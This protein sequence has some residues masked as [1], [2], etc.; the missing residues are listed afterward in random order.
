MAT[1][2]DYKIS[3]LPIQITDLKVDRSKLKIQ[4]LCVV[5]YG[6][7]PGRTFKEE[8]TYGNYMAFTYISRGRGTFRINGGPVQPLEAGSLFWE[9]PGGKYEFGPY[10]DA[11]WDEYYIMFEGSRTKEWFDS[12]ILSITDSVMHVGL[13][14]L[15][16]SK[17]EAIG[18]YMES[19]VPNNIDRAALLLESLVYEFSQTH[20]TYKTAHLYKQKQEIV[21]QVLEAIAG[22]LYGPWNEQEIWERN[23]IS[24]STLRRIVLQNTGFPLNEYVNRL[25]VSEAKKLL[26]HTTLQIKEIAHSLGY[27]DVAY[28]SRLFKKYAQTSALSFRKNN[29]AGIPLP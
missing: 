13:D 27:S 14:P 7:L 4:S 28:F 1:F 24:R 26:N 18:A 21:L 25:K 19:G 2:L 15:W 10:A 8:G 20:S 29:K 12:G 23:H 6:H 11:D 17:L 22:S 3:P 5:Q 16:I 9:W